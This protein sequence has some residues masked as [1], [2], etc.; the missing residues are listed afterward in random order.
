MFFFLEV[1]LSISFSIPLPA[2]SYFCECAVRFRWC[3]STDEGRIAVG[4]LFFFFFKPLLNSEL[5]DSSRSKRQSWKAFLLK[6]LTSSSGCYSIADFTAFDFIVFTFFLLGVFA[7]SLTGFSFFR[8]ECVFLE[9]LS[10][11]SRCL[12][13]SFFS[14]FLFRFGSPVSLRAGHVLFPFSASRMISPEGF[15]SHI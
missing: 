5:K 2:L 11:F 6:V 3:T 10:I 4:S 15:T 7:R 13:V 8:R 1:P 9:L 12:R 14:V